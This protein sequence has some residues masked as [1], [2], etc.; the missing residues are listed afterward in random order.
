MTVVR[1]KPFECHD[2]TRIRICHL[3]SSQSTRTTGQCRIRSANVWIWVVDSMDDTSIYLF[4]ERIV[5]IVNLGIDSD[6]A[7]ETVHRYTASSG[8][9]SNEKWRCPHRM[10]DRKGIFSQN[11][12]ESYPLKWPAAAAVSGAYLYCSWISMAVGLVS[13][14]NRLNLNNSTT[15]Y[16][17][18]ISTVKSPL[19]PV[20]PN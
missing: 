19:A 2:I 10:K 15:C 4:L 7:H 17:V 14:G 11:E 16:S 12:S 3:R 5:S 8:T 6:G 18:L 1:V 13:E 9:K 20:T